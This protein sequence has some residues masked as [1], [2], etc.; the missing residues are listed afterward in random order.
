M[1]IKL[2]TWILAGGYFVC[3]VMFFFVIPQF[4]TVF[5]G[6][7]VQLPVL[8]RAVC[9]LGPWGSLFLPVAI[10]LLAILKDFRFHSRLLNPVFTLILALLACCV[11]IALFSPL[12][13][14]VSSFGV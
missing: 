11:I 3:G 13:M 7:S 6:M 14:M 12:L 8:T 1:K 2:D 9:A 5:S 4:Q 10:G